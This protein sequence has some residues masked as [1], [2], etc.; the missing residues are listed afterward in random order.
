MVVVIIVHIRPWRRS[1]QEPIRQP[2][3][4]W[5]KIT[6]QEPRSLW[7]R[8]SRAGHV[9][10][11]LLSGNAPHFV[12]LC[13]RIMAA[14]L[15][16]RLTEAIKLLWLKKV[17]LHAATPEFGVR[18]P[19]SKLYTARHSSQYFNCTNC[20]KSQKTDLSLRVTPSH[21]PNHFWVTSHCAKI[22]D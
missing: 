14:L 21:P 19:A 5:T 13:T 8:T 18:A 22:S 9:P 1:S 20:T 17:K 10:T 7:E 6:E 16:G 3:I 15:G 11:P 12:C 4:Y 2:A